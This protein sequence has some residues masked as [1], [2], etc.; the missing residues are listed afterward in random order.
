MYGVSYCSPK[1]KYS[2][3]IGKEIAYAK[4]IDDAYAVSLGRKRH[5]EVNARILSDI[6]SNNDAPS[7]AESLVASEL[8]IH[9]CKAF[10]LVEEDDE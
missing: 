3:S 10:N 1:D 9:L 6:V 5:H 4:M 8:C 7:W 2:K